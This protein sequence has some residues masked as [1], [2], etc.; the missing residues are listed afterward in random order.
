MVIIEPHLPLRPREDL[1]RMAGR[2]PLSTGALIVGEWSLSAAA[3]TDRHQ[4]E[5]I[6]HVIEGEL[7]VDCD[8]SRT[9]VGP[10]DFVVV[11]AGSRARYAAPTYARMV[12]VYGP[13]EDGHAC[14]DTEYLELDGSSA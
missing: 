4:H 13:S 9:V 3:W 7:H 11:P 12:F 6:N 14:S 5:E 1:P 8:G 2:P 10:G